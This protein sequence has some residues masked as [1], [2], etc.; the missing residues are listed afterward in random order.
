MKLICLEQAK[1]IRIELFY[2]QQWL[3]INSWCSHNTIGYSGDYLDY[4][5]VMDA[6]FMFK[7]LED[8]T[9]FVLRWSNA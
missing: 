6:W 5:S 7:K 9:L 2:Y 8:M 1:T 3:D 4:G